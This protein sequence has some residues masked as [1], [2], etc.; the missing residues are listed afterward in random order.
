MQQMQE[1][2]MLKQNAEEEINT[3]VPKTVNCKKHDDNI[4]S[5]IAMSCYCCQGS[6]SVFPVSFRSC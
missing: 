3:F 4:I 5:P 6:T 2:H 1:K